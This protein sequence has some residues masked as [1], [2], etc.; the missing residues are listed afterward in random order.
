MKNYITHIHYAKYLTFEEKL[1]YY[2][3][4]IAKLFYFLAVKCRLL[5]FKKG[6]KKTEKVNAY[7]ISIG[8][9]TTG[10]TGKTPVCVAI[11]N[12]FSQQNKKTAILSRGYGGKL[13]NTHVNTISDGD[14][15]FFSA[16]MSGDEPYWLA[17]NA[18]KTSVLTCKNRIEAAKTFV[19]KIDENVSRV[20]VCLE[21]IEE[22]VEDLKDAIK[23]SVEIETFLYELSK[24]EEISTEI[25]ER[26]LELWHKI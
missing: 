19:A 24:N 13:S 6:F 21:E 17:Y 18:Q 3:L 25:K 20:E 23:T 26:A 16:H 22:S 11:A 7:V 10:G 4:G 8:N 2:G 9:I 14:N 12:Y 1:A 15:I 5:A